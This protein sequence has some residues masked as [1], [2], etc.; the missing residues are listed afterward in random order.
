MFTVLLYTKIP[1]NYIGK[2]KLYLSNSKI[3]LCKKGR[4]YSIL[5]DNIIHYNKYKCNIEI[6]YHKNSYNKNCNNKLSV[7]IIILKFNNKKISNN[8]FD[9]ISIKKKK[10]KNYIYNPIHQFEPKKL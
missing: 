5:Y 10:F 4:L 7:S 1:L 8:I 3:N 6:K 2:F 9:M